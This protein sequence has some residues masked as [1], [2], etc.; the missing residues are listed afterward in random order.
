MFPLSLLPA[1]S[2]INPLLDGLP[3]PM[4]LERLSGLRVRS[5]SSESA[6]HRLGRRTLR[7]VRGCRHDADRIAVSLGQTPVST[8]ISR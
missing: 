7:F 6:A 8:T 3:E 1:N 5:R 4:M 2:L